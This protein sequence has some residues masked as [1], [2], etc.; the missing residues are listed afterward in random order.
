MTGKLQ[1]AKDKGQK[2]TTVRFS[3]RQVEANRKHEGGFLG[4]LASLAA[5]AIPAILG[6]VA[7]GAISGAV[8]KSVS[9]NGLFLHRKKQCVWQYHLVPATYKH[10][11]EVKNALQIQH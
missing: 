4:L 9:G 1:A 3:R 11:K 2:S 5:T 8:K 7:T 10:H 6:A